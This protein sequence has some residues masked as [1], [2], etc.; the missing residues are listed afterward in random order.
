[1]AN[2]KISIILPVLNE[3]LV[4]RDLKKIEEEF[5]RLNQ[6]FEIICVFDSGAEKSSSKLRLPHLPHVVPLFYPVARFGT[7]FARCYGFNKS[8]GSLIFFFEGNFSISPEE[9]LLYLNLMETARA[10]I[11]IGSKRHPLSRVYYSSF[12]H[13]ISKIYHLLVRIIFGLNVTDT[14]V[15][16][17]LYKRRVLNEVIPRIIIKNWGFD[18]EILVVAHALGF[19]R[20][21]EAPIEIK[22]HFTSREIT[23]NNISNLLRDTLAIAYRKYWL[24]YYQ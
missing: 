9:F 18:L 19:K 17:K 20:I 13:L 12:R 24:K 5:T 16:L 21:V 11:V 1:M 3:S 7:G 14:Q 15:G 2:R 8:K 22:R 6:N 10:D 23:S 4:F